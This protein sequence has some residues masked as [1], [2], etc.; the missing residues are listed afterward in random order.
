MVRED[1]QLTCAL[2][3]HGRLFTM[4]G[5]RGLAL[6][7]WLVVDQANRKVSLQRLYWL[8]GSLT[9]PISGYVKC[10]EMPPRNVQQDTTIRISSLN[11]IQLASQSK[12]SPR[13]KELGLLQNSNFSDASFASFGQVNGSISEIAPGKSRSRSHRWL[14]MALSLDR[15]SNRRS[16]YSH[17]QNYRK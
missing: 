7:I 3:P 12:R 4:P 10:L 5:W 13:S 14:A 2:I 15:W 8:I 17:R 16:T 1:L 6:V 9:Q 11:N